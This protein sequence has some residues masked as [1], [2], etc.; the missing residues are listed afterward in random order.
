MQ[1]IMNQNTKHID[2]WLFIVW[3]LSH[4]ITITFCFSI[5][6]FSAFMLL[7]E[8]LKGPVKY[9]TSNLQV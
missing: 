9:H 2:T 4:I 6:T 5:S 8:N 7:A 1:R 3:I